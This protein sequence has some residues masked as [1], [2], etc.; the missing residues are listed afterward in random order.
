MS[1]ET[2][3]TRVLY[4][5]APNRLSPPQLAAAFSSMSD[6]D[7][8]WLAVNQVLDEEHASAMLDVTA[9]SSANRDHAAGRG[10]A[11]ATLKQRL[12]NLR[13]KPAQPPATPPASRRQ[14][15]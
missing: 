2:T 3:A 8:R 5:R 11:L 6:D 14:K 9:P 12:A 15:V 7:P 13:Q 4:I 10:E 1:T